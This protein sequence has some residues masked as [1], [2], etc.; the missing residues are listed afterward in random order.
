MF[1]WVTAL[2]EYFNIPQSVTG[3]LRACEHS[4]WLA[5][6]DR[7]KLCY[8]LLNPVKSLKI[9]SKLSS[10]SE[11]N[12][13]GHQVF[14]PP[15]APGCLRL[16]SPELPCTS[17]CLPASVPLL[18]QIQPLQH[19]AKPCATRHATRIRMSINKSNVNY[20]NEASYFTVQPYQRY[21][22]TV[23]VA[24][25]EPFVKPSHMINQFEPCTP[26]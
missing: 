15:E 24:T 19:T 14:I 10:R 7:V 16:S 4:L 18:R 26:V 11:Q 12:P 2:L 21:Q 20:M 13:V 1:T 3:I 9:N 23:C 17:S 8:P 22:M 6:A 5:A 25:Y